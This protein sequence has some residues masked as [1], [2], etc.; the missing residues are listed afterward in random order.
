MPQTRAHHREQVVGHGLGAL[1]KGDVGEQGRPAR[2]ERTLGGQ[3]AHTSSE[4]AA[5]GLAFA[6]TWRERVLRPA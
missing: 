6:Y 2:R 1:A 5:G 3:H 4:A